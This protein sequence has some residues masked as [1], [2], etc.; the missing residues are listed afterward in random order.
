MTNCE[1]TVSL[2]FLS[3]IGVEHPP[4]SFVV[5][6]WPGDN[7]LAATRAAS[8]LLNHRRDFCCRDEKAPHQVRLRSQPPMSKASG[9]VPALPALAAYLGRIRRSQERLCDSPSN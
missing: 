3:L 6:C 1:A 8:R 5:P 4:A 2:G 7:K 9:R